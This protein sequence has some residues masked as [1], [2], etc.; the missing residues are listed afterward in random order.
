[1]EKKTQGQ[2]EIQIVVAS[3][4]LHFDSVVHSNNDVC[5]PSSLIC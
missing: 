1:M 4:L 3:F 2:S 5:E